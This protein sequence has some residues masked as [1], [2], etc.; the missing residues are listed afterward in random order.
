[1]SRTNKLIF[2]IST[3]ILLIV[4]AAIVGFILWPCALEKRWADFK[5]RWEAQ[6]ESFEISAHQ[7]EAIE[8]SQNFAKHP[9]LES[10]RTNDPQAIERLNRMEA[11]SLPDLHGFL[12]SEKKAFMPEPLARQ[13]IDYYTPFAADFDALAEASARPGC[14]AEPNY[15]AGSLIPSEWLVRMIPCQRA[16]AACASAAIALGDE[17]A[18]TNQTV[19]LLDI[20]RLVRSNNTMISSLIGARFEQSAYTMISALAPLGV[21]K[22]A[23]RSRLLEALNR[24]QRSPGEEMAKVL[25]YERALAL[26]LIG[27]IGSGAATAPI[28]PRSIMGRVSLASSR[29]ALCEDSQHILLAPEGRLK[30]EITLDDLRR[31]DEVTQRGWKGGKTLASYLDLIARALDQIS[32][33][34]LEK[35]WKKEQARQEA[36]DALCP[37]K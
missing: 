5:A 30:Q 6:G 13:V 20:G 29:L 10:V 35:T 26:K 22:E 11:K 34:H 8:D 7:P 4:V 32:C 1:M 23:N 27:K 15:K 31:Y 24:R 37:G 3:P 16:L 19:L 36:R 28:M 18:F 12:R 17:D 33:E 21:K 25:R 14:R 2:A 9:W